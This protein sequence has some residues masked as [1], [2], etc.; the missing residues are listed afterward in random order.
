MMRNLL[1]FVAYCFSDA[2]ING[3]VAQCQNTSKGK[4]GRGEGFRSQSVASHQC[5]PVL[6]KSRYHWWPWIIFLPKFNFLNNFSS[7]CSSNTFC[8]NSNQFDALSMNISFSEAV[9]NISSMENAFVL[10]MYTHE[11]KNNL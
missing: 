5:K 3:I 1:S 4:R 7:Y 10:C 11:V 8:H 6:S 9:N 2:K